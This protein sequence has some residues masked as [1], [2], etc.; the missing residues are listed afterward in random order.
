VGFGIKLWLDSGYGA[1]LALFSERE[2][3]SFALIPL[4]AQDKANITRAQ[5]GNRQRE[6]GAFGQTRHAPNESPAS[7]AEPINPLHS[8]VQKAVVKREGKTEVIEGI[9]AADHPIIVRLK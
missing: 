1:G 4:S 3:L 2:L 5:T 8:V 6:T 9:L 7:K